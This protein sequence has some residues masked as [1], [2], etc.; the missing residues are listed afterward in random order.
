MKAHLR[1]H[2]RAQ[3][4]SLSAVEH[5]HRSNLAARAVTGLRA[6]R[7][8]K[9][10][11][12]YLPFDRETDTAALIRTARR[13]GVRIYVPVIVDRRHSRIRFYPLDART[14][15]GVFGIAV[16]KRLHRPTAP[17]WLNLIVVPLVGVDAGG[18]RLGMGGGFYDRALEFRR[19][20][21]H[22]PGPRAIGL[23]FDCQRT[24]SPF[25]EPWD[26]SLDS[27]ATE[28]GLQQF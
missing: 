4:R 27:L 21:H 5:G 16:P 15:R 24:E 13:R 7:A 10:V 11:A 9:R 28:S 3:R 6:F 18:R 22:W 2:L 14:R 25:A 19:R 1:K 23:A 8:G 12:L 17:R 26:V 20:R